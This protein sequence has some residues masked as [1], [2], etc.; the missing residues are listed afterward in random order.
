MKIYPF[1]VKI[2][3]LNNKEVRFLDK[4]LINGIP[5]ENENTEI[6]ASEEATEDALQTET[7]EPQEEN[8]ASE[9]AASEA[10]EN[11]E[12]KDDDV[13]ESEIS[14]D[15]EENTEIDEDSLCV[16]CGEKRKGEESEYCPDCEAAMYK[17]KIPFLAWLSGI[18][19]ICVSIFAFVIAML[20][21]APALQ[22][23]RGDIYAS[24]KRWYPAYL[25]YSQVSSVV[26]EI[27]SIL[28]AETPFVAAGKKI[29]EKTIISYANSRS[30]LDAAYM[31]M[32]IHGENL[33]NVLP[34]LEEYVEIYDEFYNSYSLIAE[35]LDAMLTG[36]TADETFKALLEFEDSPEMNKVYLNYFLFNAADYYQLS[37]DEQLA[38]VRAADESAKAQGKDFSWLYSLEIADILCQEGRYDEALEFIDV[39]AENDKSNYRA[40]DLKMRIA[41]AK[42]D[43]DGASKI[44][45]EFKT[46]NEGF[47]SAYALEAAYHRCTGDLEKSKLIIEEGLVENDTSSELHRQL[48]LL[49]LING[50]YS[51]AYEEAFTADSNAS[52]MANYYM[53]SSGFTPQLDNTVYLCAS[54]CKKHGLAGSENA[55]YLD[56]IIDYYKDFVPS[57]QASEVLDGEKTAKEVL[58][59]GVCDL[60]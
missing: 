24:Q 23:A 29:E 35:P 52:Y 19:V 2:N 11:P 7:Q 45:A 31:A 33:A 50:S 15:S 58:T 20:A 59:E 28:G 9:D 38:Y 13:S 12:E 3:K 4:E 26:D 30:P 55:V 60:A 54:L 53:D 17:S 44:L 10:A 27:S 14:E 18:A 25:E 6:E 47:D 51:D 39:L 37:V 43:T 48:A 22:A 1:S 40:F 42:G 41:I 8:E 5:E 32:M 36:A 57:K 21:S 16:I 46:N 34:G 49:H 56:Q